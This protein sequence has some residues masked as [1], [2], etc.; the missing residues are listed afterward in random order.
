VQRTARTLDGLIARLPADDPE[1][2]ALQARAAKYGRACGCSAGAA[3]LV[4]SVLLSAAYFAAGGE[5]GVRSGF[6]CVVLVFVATLAGK[7]VGISL[8]TLRLG[9]LRRSVDRRLRR[10]GRLGHVHVH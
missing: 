7:L 6:A 3:F 5:L 10:Q 1:K 2:D 4:A 9:L 8:A